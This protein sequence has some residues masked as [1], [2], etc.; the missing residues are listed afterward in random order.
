MHLRSL[1]ALAFLSAKA[2]YA[3]DVP[4]AVSI[5]FGPE[6]D[7][8]KLLDCESFAAEC[9]LTIEEFKAFN[10]DAKCPDLEA[11][12]D[13]CLVP[14]YPP[15]STSLGTTL[16]GT[17]ASAS[18]SASMTSSPATATW[19]MTTAPTAASMGNSP[20]STAEESTVTTA[21]PSSSQTDVPNSAGE[22]KTATCS[23]L[24]MSVFMGYYVFISV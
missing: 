15:E 23:W 12:H 2:I 13:Y 3:K 4:C 16:N 22:T 21:T 17:T 24:I 19:G 20:A 10:P 7:S 14:L 5:A 11:D 18:A 9:D 8:L 6:D 1:I